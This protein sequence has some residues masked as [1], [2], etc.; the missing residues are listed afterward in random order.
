MVPL[1]EIS[2]VARIT[3]ARVAGLALYT[4]HECK[5]SLQHVAVLP[6]HGILTTPPPLRPIFKRKPQS[7]ARKFDVDLDVAG[8]PN[9]SVCQLHSLGLRIFQL[10][11]SLSC[12]TA[13]LQIAKSLSGLSRS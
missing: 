13:A 5:G 7:S 12:S 10:V 8:L 4:L 1:T 9:A 3:G 11:R 6:W 2:W